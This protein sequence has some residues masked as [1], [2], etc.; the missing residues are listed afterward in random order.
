MIYFFADNHYGQRPGWNL[1][2]CLHEDFP[3]SFHEDDWEALASTD[4]AADCDLLIL[5]LIATTG[6]LAAPGPEAESRV[7]AYVEH[8]GNVLMLHGSSAAF[9][10]W[11][12][13]RPLVG[14]RWVRS[15]DPDGMAA[16][17]HPKEPFR[18]EVC[19]CRHPLCRR[20]Q[21][22]DLPEDEIYTQLEQTCPVWSL[23]QTTLASGT[24]V[25]CHEALTPWGGRMVGFLPGHRP[26]VV[27]LPALVDNVRIL[28]D[29]LRQD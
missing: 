22:M 3:I 10:H 13:W 20:L 11:D 29:D 6:K 28:I 24:F 8:G 17:V 7:R 16:S 25:Q 1:M 12:W 21:P 5:N 27:R 18:V 23:L 9:W 19:K 2:Q 14:F 4:L 26:E 15:Q